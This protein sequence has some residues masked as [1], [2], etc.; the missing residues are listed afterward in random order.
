MHLW[1]KMKSNRIPWLT[2]EVKKMIRRGVW[3]SDQI[4]DAGQKLLKLKYHVIRSM[5]GYICHKICG[6]V[7]SNALAQSSK[8]NK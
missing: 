7:P 6:Y 2:T 4:V 8:A 3:L 5:L 1:L